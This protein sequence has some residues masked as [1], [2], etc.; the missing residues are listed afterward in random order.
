MSSTTKRFRALVVTL[1]VVAA[2]NIAISKVATLR[3][4]APRPKIDVVHMT[5]GTAK[6]ATLRPHA[7][8][9]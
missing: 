7:P 5:D 1:A 9:P 3:P 4:H 6:V 8:R 2:T